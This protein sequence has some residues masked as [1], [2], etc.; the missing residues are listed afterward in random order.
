[1]LEL[2]EINEC[3][4]I[5]TIKLRETLNKETLFLDFENDELEKDVSKEMEHI[6]KVNSNNNLIWRL[7]V[8]DDEKIG[9]IFLK[10]NALKRRSHVATLSIAILSSKCGQ[11]LG[12]KSIKKAIE[13]VKQ[14]GVSIVDLVVDTT[15]E[16]AIS[17]YKKIGFVVDGCFINSKYINHDRTKEYR[18]EY[19]MSLHIKE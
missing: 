14:R 19:H 11:G 1:M 12:K 17:L 7:L 2:K 5:E 3:D 4:A 15:N 13:L 9:F 6:K 10:I 18:S 8:E 16:V